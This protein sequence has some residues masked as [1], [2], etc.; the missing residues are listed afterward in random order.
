MAGE[1]NANG[2]ARRRRNKKKSRSSGA[3]SSEST[4]EVS[5]SRSDSKERKK[6]AA[7]SPPA[8]TH[9]NPLFVITAVILMP[10]ALYNAYLYLFLQHP[11][12]ISFLYPTIRPA[13]KVHDTRQLLIVGTISS[14][15]SQ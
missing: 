2:P 8:E 14:G 3:G 9:K 13:V 12:L 5:T 1:L 15:T 11:E 10:Y 7:T 4:A 6:T